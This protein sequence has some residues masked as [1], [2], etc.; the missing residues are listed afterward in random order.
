MLKVY[1]DILPNVPH[2]PLLYPNLGKREQEK[3]MF[4]DRAYEGLKD[5]MVEIVD[6]VSQA[7]YILIPHNYP[8]VIN[9]SEYLDKQFKLA[10]EN[11][12]KVVA[13]WHGDSD[14]HVDRDNL[15]L[16]RTCQYGYKKR[17]NEVM[18]PPYAVDLLETDPDVRSKKSDK[19]I[20][21]FCGWAR[22]KNLKNLIGTL[23]KNSIVQIVSI[24]SP[25]LSARRKGISFR[26]DAIK[27]LQKSKLTDA[28]FVIRSSYSGHKE[29][30][31]MDPKKAREEYIENILGS[32]L[33]LVI[34]G[35]G[36]YSYRF[37]EALSLGRVPLFVDTDCVLPFES[38]I[39]Y[40]EFILKVN[41][42][43]IKNIDKIA[44]DFW[45]N[46]SDGDFKKMQQKA[47]EVYE[48]YLSVP[49]FLR[50]IVNEIL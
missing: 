25:K 4:M 12:K 41:H 46:L 35:D 38:K 39:D 36:N 30:I 10:S 22:Y 16:F 31:S 23:I 5:P 9:N 44:A 29:T 2:V 49:A 42:R 45:S 20:I 13:F 32:D 24:A 43:D 14:E 33:S 50:Y 6:D 15:I 40:S 37:Y 21:G 11:N 26:M 8:N 3:I 17:D 19:P 27:I 7:K 47:R 18:I 28:N 34:K 1:C 48:K